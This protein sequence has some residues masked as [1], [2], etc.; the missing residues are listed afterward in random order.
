MKTP[1]QLLNEFIEELEGKAD[2]DQRVIQEKF[3]LNSSY[4]K[5][6][7]ARARAIRRLMNG[8]DEPSKFEFTK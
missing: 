3:G 4:A 2:H 6:T 8:K 7:R 5:L 1:T